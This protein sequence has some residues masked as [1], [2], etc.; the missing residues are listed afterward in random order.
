[1]IVQVEFSG[2][3]DS[4]CSKMSLKL[5][6]ASNRDPSRLRHSRALQ[7]FLPAEALGRCV[8]LISGSGKVKYL[9]TLA[10][11]RVQKQPSDDYVY[12]CS[13]CNLNMARSNFPRFSHLLC[14]RG[15]H[16]CLYRH[17]RITT[18]PYM[19]LDAAWT[20]GR[21]LCAGRSYQ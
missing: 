6:V 8:G 10:G 9:R 14:R 2:S 7:C 13:L 17:P 21:D 15:K 11:P 18:S 5:V 4:P 1:M 12:A 20:Q 19:E 16:M 3:T